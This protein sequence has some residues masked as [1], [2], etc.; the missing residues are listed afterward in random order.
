MHAASAAG[1]NG[2]FLL[3]GVLG[4]GG[5]LI[6]LAGL[7]HPALPDPDLP[8]PDLPD[9]DLPDPDLPDSA[10]PDSAGPGVPQPGAA[11]SR[12]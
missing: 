5:G 8:D 1:L 6:A 2:T 10:L 11:P 9:P 12:G 3:A 4:L 7:R